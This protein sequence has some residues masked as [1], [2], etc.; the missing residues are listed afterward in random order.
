MLTDRWDSGWA[1]Y[2]ENRR[3]PLHRVNHALRGVVV[4][5]GL[6]LVEFRYEPRSFAWG[7]AMALFAVFAV[8]VMWIWTRVHARLSAR[9]KEELERVKGNCH[10][11]AQANVRVLPLDLSQSET[12]KLSTEAAIQIFGQIDILINNGGISQR[13]FAKDTLI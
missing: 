10:S 13:S 11:S 12:L 3:V 2:L 4:P 1:A 8:A 9:R 7:A 6:S 5:P